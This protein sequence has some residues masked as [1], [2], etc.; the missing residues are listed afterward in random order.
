M[1]KIYLLMAALLLLGTM[2]SAQKI[3][4]TVKG[5]L[6]DSTT[7][8]PLTDAT[9]SIIRVSDSSLISFTLT[10]SKGDFQVK[11]LDAG[12][13]YIAASY[14]GMETLRKNFAI[15]VDAQQ[16]DLG[17]LN[18]NRA[19]KTM[20][21]VVIEEAPVQIKGDTL[22]FKADA[23]KTKPNATVE[24]L[25]KK[26][27]GMAVEKDGTVKAQGETVQKVY[28]DGKEFF[29]ND[30]KLATKNLSAEMVDRVDVFDDMSEQAKFN[31][32]DDGSRS[33]AINL[34]LKK[35]KKKSVFGKAYAGAGTEDRYDVGL[36]A[37]FFKGAMQS[38]VIAKANNTNNVGFSLT[39]ML[40]M[41]GG[42]GMQSFGGGGTSI[43]SGGGAMGGMI[44]SM[45][46]SSGMSGF[47]LGSNG[48]GLTSSS[49]LG[50]NYRDTWS[51][52]F[53]INGSYFFNHTNTEDNQSSYRQTL[54]PDS[55]I[56]TN[57]NTYSNNSNNNLNNYFEKAPR[58]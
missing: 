42:G 58:S 21:E 13:Y 4:G 18:M 47:N 29:N 25:L 57:D 6:Q 16:H 49:Q 10:G 15:A 11:N 46:G 3:S 51:K 28:V 40:G 14:T 33:K 30:P 53:D 41:F 9:V 43:V 34:K 39:D 5:V 35:D 26:V 50:F 36:T 45:I 52:T 54:A 48:R 56:N 7:S 38:S 27:P 20:D 32:I 22:S 1:K 23:F 44:R 2:A 55:S 8:S 19:Y 24:D 17:V 31:G 37:N 12:E